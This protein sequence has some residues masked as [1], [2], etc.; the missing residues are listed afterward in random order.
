MFCSGNFQLIEKIIV[1][2]FDYTKGKYNLYV[3]PETC[4]LLYMA[5]FWRSTSTMASLSILISTADLY[6]SVKSQNYGYILI[7]TYIPVSLYLTSFRFS[8]CD[9]GCAFLT[10]CG[11]ESAIKAQAALHEQKTLPG[12]CKCFTYN[13]TVIINT[14]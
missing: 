4:F 9:L 7:W 6:C 12:V 14:T 2:T 11:R 10:Y 8:I 13:I 5:R 3:Q 1:H